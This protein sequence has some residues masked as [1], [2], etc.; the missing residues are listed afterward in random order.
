MKSNDPRIESILFSEE[1]I[2]RRV[3]ELASDICQDYSDAGVVH[4]VAILKGAFVFA[5]DLG[6]EICRQGGPELHFEF[7][8]ARAYGNAIGK[9]GQIPAVEI[10]GIPEDLSGRDILLVEDILDQGATL[11]GVHRRLLDTHAR[12]VRVCVLLEKELQQPSSETAMLRNHICPEYVGF[13]VPDRWVG[14]YGLDAC[15]DLR[16]LPYIAVIREEYYT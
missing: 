4:M 8:R 12:S 7:V 16:E 10:D 13:Q 15:E 2:H 1:K 6:R 3:H 5:A 9:R 11:A 14:G